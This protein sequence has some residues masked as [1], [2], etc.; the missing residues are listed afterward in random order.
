M[1]ITRSIALP[2][3]PDHL[4]QISLLL[5]FD[6]TLV[7]LA[8]RPHRVRVG[9]RLQLVMSRLSARL[10]GRLAI[11]SGRPLD[12]VRTMFGG[13]PFAVAGSHGAELVWPDGRKT[14]S[15]SLPGRDVVLAATRELARRHPGVLVEDKPFGIALHYRLAPAA[16]DECHALAGQLAGDYGFALQP[17][18]MVIELKLSMAD[19]GSAVRSLMSEAPMAGTRPIF[20]GDDDTDEAG[21]RAALDL[22]GAGVRIGVPAPTAAIYG[23]ANVDA[24]LHWLETADFGLAPPQVPRRLE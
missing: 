13:I 3:P 12:Q 22:H 17:G 9:E 21:F 8:A 14:V 4:E 24:T 23:L 15:P 2:S 1:T 5:D 7:E 10:A 19:K 6:G 11:V 20:V 16:Q 18:K